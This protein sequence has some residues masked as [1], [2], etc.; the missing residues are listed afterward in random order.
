MRT[1]L[2]IKGNEM[3]N[4]WTICLTATFTLALFFAIPTISSFA[5]GYAHNEP[6]E[7]VVPT[8]LRYKLSDQMTLI[9]IHYY[10]GH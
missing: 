6:T 5:A 9:P 3:K 4:L 8:E 10:F 1:P 7:V 2:E